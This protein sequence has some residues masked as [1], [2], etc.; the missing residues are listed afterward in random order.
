[1]SNLNKI[2]S[3]VCSER[4]K[5]LR[6]IEQ[7]FKKYTNLSKDID[8]RFKDMFRERKGSLDGLEDF[9]MLNS[10]VK[11]NVGDIRIALICLKRLRDISPYKIEESDEE[12][13]KKILE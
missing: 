6:D 1:M 12:L 2:I 3:D 11:R 7:Y 9:H 4:G 8:I 13:L 5:I 10:I